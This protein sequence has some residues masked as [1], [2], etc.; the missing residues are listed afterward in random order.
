MRSR[1]SLIFTLTL[2]ISDACAIVAAYVLA[3]VLRVK[4]SAVPTHTL[5]SAREFLISL[6]ILLPFVIIFFS[7]I[8]TY[9]SERQSKTARVARIFFGAIGAMLFMIA[10][11]YFMISPLFPSKLVP[12]Y[13]LIFSIVFLGLERG[14]LYF[15]RWRR[16][17]KLIGVIDT[18]L[19]GDNAVAKQL[20]TNIREDQSY[21]LRAVVG[22]AKFATHKTFAAAVR[23]FQPD[24][25]IQVATTAAP[26]LDSDIL[27]FAQQNY[28]DFKFVPREIANLSDNFVPEIFLGD[29]PVLSAQPTALTGWGRVAKRA[30]D[31]TVSAIFLIIFSWLYLIIAIINKIVFGKVFFKQ[32]RLT[33]G[34]QKFQV[35]KFQT[36]RNDLNGL[37]PE[38]AFAK[39]GHPEL[40]KKYRDNGDFLAGD[41]RYG[42]WAKI[43]RKTSLDELPQM[44]NVLRGDISLVGPRALIPQELAKYENKHK[45][46]NVKSGLTG[47]AVVSGRRDLPWEQRRQLDVYYVQNWSFGLDLQIIAKTFWQVVS[48]RGAE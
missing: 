21:K 43:L 10:V 19:I 16:R 36:V 34:D 30:F 6:L 37:T 26:D 45:I 8:G 40:V 17:E 23:N 48:G 2:I 18:V 39:I 47:L 32:T 28:I 41:P 4:L 42:T 25:I 9:R 14:I 29:V 13:G 15:W 3:F 22:Q 38:Q 46:L 7:L 31:V 44:W 11:H 20:A 35:L 27:A 33:R 12:I 24:L 5:V 1:N